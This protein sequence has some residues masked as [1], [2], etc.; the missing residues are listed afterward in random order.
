MCRW[1]ERDPAGYQDGPSLYSYLGRN[2]MAGTDPLGLWSWGDLW[3][4][5]GGDRRGNAERT[6]RENQRLVERHLQQQLELGLISPADHNW[7]RYDMRTDIDQA[8]GLLHV[9]ESTQREQVIE[10]EIAITISLIPVGD[11]AAASVNGVRALRATMTAGR[12]GTVGT[13]SATAGAASSIAA[14]TTGASAQTPVVIGENMAR[15]Q[16]Y[17]GKVGGEIFTGKTMAANRAWIQA[18]RDSGRPIIDIG[19]D[20]VRRVERFLAGRRP[21]SIFYNM[22]RTELVGYGN[23]QRAW[24]RTGRFDGTVSGFGGS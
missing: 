20:F 21:D 24:V 3:D 14:R 11:A 13:A 23:L 22:E 16:A 2:P 19:P 7:Q 6:L 15:V 4:Y 9:I 18:A 8:L 5:F 10:T 12:T 17:A 1:L